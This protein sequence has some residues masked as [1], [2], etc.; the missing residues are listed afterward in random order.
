MK[1]YLILVIFIYSITIVINDQEFIKYLDLDYTHSL[2]LQ[3]GNLFI[4]HKNGVLVYNYNFTIVLYSYDFSGTSIIPTEKDNNF[5]SIIQCQDNNNKYVIALINENIYIFSSRG[6]YLFSV[7]N[8][9]LFSDFSTSVLFQ[10]YSFL[11][12][13]YEGSIYYFIVTFLNTENSIKINEF[14]INIGTHSYEIVK[15][16]TYNQDS[17]ISDSVSCE[18]TYFNNHFRFSQL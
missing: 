2:C 1:N 9:N 17:I 10:Y 16:I 6:Q 8:D 13:K 3:N 18:I 5:T 12:Y 4:L 14:A 15:Q 11:Y 7:S